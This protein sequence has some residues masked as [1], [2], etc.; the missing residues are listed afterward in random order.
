MSKSTPRSLV[1]LKCSA[2]LKLLSSIGN[3]G[4]L[5][6]Y[7]AWYLSSGIETLR[8]HVKN[9]CVRIV[10]YKI[11]CR[12]ICRS[13]LILNYDCN[14]TTIMICVSMWFPELSTMVVFLFREERRTVSR[15]TLCL[16]KASASLRIV[17]SRSVFFSAW[18]WFV[19]F[20]CSGHNIGDYW[21]T[22]FHCAGAEAFSKSIL[23]ARLSITAEM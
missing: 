3:F 16:G 19:N 9:T 18:F 1:Q 8:R 4:G 23:R 17:L 20:Y 10:M 12:R 22:I 13:H 7:R 5:S 21:I 6:F 2:A 14:V 15:T 11:S